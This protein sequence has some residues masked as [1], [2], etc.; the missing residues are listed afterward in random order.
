MPKKLDL[1]GQVFGQLTALYSSEKQ[2]GEYTWVCQCTCGNETRVKVSNLRNGHTKSCGCAKHKPSPHFV[3]LTGKKFGEWTVLERA[4]KESYWLCQCSCG[5]K[6]E[7]FAP[8]LKKGLSTSCGHIK[9]GVVKKPIIGLRFG[10]LEVEEQLPY[11]T[12]RCKCDCGKTIYVRRCNLTS[13]NTKSCGCNAYKAISKDMSNQVFGYLQ[14][15]YPTDERKSGSIV[16]RCRCNNCGN[17]CDVSQHALVDGKT[18]SCGCIRSTGELSIQNVLNEANVSFEREKTYEDLINPETN[19]KL[20]YDF[21][22]PSLNRLIEF[23]GVQ[24]YQ[25]VDLFGGQEEFLKRQ[26]LDL[27]K[28]KYALNNNIALVRI[29]YWEKDNITLEMLLGKKYLI[30]EAEEEMIEVEG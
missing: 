7:V 22:L 29:P 23:D 11:S 13:G 8:S 5:V 16:W 20:R 1:T 3:D 4:E 15:L 30:E 10:M 12:C 9:R 28:N 24:H 2:G 21:Y 25:E 19:Y 14:P 17:E 27:L 18:N 26:S 6:R